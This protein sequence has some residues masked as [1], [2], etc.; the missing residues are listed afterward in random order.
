MP[1]EISWPAGMERDGIVGESGIA[2]QYV[3]SDHIYGRTHPIHALSGDA[4]MML[5]HN[6]GECWCDRGIGACIFTQE[7]MPDER[8][9][10][11]R[12]AVRLHDE[13]RI[14]AGEQIAIVSLAELRVDSVANTS[15]CW[16]P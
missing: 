13:E 8:M 16:R 5:I 11:I 6:D 7:G 10:H 1:P 3:W 12:E 2:W 14:D 4:C 15:G 9:E